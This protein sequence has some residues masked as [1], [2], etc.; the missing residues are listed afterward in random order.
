MSDD[1][2]V[3]KTHHIFVAIRGSDALIVQEIPFFVQK[4]PIDSKDLLNIGNI[5]IFAT[6]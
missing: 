1:E 5:F 2:N 4:V 3:K 6:I